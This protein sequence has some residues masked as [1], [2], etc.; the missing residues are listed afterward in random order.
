MTVEQRE[1][2]ILDLVHKLP[3][4]RRIRLALTILRQV[5]PTQIPLDEI[6]GHDLVSDTYKG[7]EEL[8]Q[9]IEDRRQSYLAGEGKNISRQELMAKIYAEISAES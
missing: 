1:A 8:A 4:H 2:K 6:S 3:I 7:E 9:R 5:E